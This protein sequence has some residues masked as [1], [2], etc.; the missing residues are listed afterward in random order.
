MIPIVNSGFQS[1]KDFPFMW[2]ILERGRWDMS[3]YVR[4]CEREREYRLM[5]YVQYFIELGIYVPCIIWRFVI[6]EQ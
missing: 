3:I 6:S 4:V 5:M 2:V 1:W